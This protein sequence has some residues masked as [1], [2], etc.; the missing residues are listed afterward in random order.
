M[1]PRTT[2]L[3]FLFG[4]FVLTDTQ[5]ARAD[6]LPRGCAEAGHQRALEGVAHYR[7]SG[8]PDNIIAECYTDAWF[9]IQAC[10]GRLPRAISPTQRWADICFHSAEEVRYTCMYECLSAVPANAPSRLT[11]CTEECYDRGVNELD[12]CVEFITQQGSSNIA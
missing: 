7:E 3:F 8:A 9:E 4:A 10:L 12:R 2:I 1:R 6:D 5:A 11:E